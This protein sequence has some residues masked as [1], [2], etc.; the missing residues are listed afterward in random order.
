[1]V[2]LVPVGRY[3]SSYPV[4]SETYWLAPAYRVDEVGLPLAR[5]S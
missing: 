4:I 5:V 3:A 2:V 1:M